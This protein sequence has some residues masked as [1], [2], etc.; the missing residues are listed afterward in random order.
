MRH[1]LLAYRELSVEGMI[2]DTADSG[3]GMEVGVVVSKN[4]FLDKYLRAK[5]QCHRA[6]WS[7]WSKIRECNRKIRWYRWTRSKC[8]Q[9]QNS[10]DSQSCKHSVMMKD[11]CEQY[12]SCYTSKK[13]EFRDFE[14]NVKMMERDRKAEWR[15]LT[16]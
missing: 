2:M 15:G 8:N 9:Y 13:K 11:T 16:R 6:R 10:M 3:D 14:S 5:N 1:I 12:T 7:H 4:G